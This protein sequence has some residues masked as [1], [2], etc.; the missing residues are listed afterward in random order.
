MRIGNF[1]L[2]PSGKGRLWIER[3]GDDPAAGEGGDFPI[4]Q[5]EDV[6]RRFYEDH[7]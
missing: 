3:C 2:R 6:I 7:F 4:A 1:T 5:F